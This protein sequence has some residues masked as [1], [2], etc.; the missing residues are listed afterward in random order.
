[1]PYISNG[2]LDG[3]KWSVSHSVSFSSG[4]NIICSWVG[5]K[6]GTDKRKF[7]LKKNVTL[8]VVQI[9]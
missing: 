1:M 2:T 9:L 6:F 5:I 3:N 4:T 7:C 8:P